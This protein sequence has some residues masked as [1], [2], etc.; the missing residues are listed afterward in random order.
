M[1]GIA[2][3]VARKVET[4]IIRGINEAQQLAT[5]PFIRNAVISSNRSYVDKNADQIRSLIQEWQDSWRAQSSQDEFPVFINKYATD[6]L[7]QWHAIRKSDYLAIVVVDNQGALVLSSFP[8]VAFFYG[9]RLWWQAVMQ[10]QE[11]QA[12]VSDLSFAP[13]F[14]THV[15]NVGVPLWDDD[16]HNVVGAISILL[17]RDSLF[18]SISEVEAGKTGH[19]MLVTTDGMPILCPTFSLEEHVVPASIV[20]AFQQDTAGWLVADPDAHGAQN[21]IV[22]YSP[23]H[24][25]SIAKTSAGDYPPWH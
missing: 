12:F 8:Q 24:F 15:L 16:R 20:D 11:T 17:R 5:I 2:V 18:R 22:G 13:A 21:A 9:K 14:G 4:Q 19:A 6:Y 3:E 25:G 1:K 23:L 7:I 10:Q